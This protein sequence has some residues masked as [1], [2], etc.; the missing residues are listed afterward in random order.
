[1]HFKIQYGGQIIIWLKRNKRKMNEL[2]L[3]KK[4]MNELQ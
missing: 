3:S 2:L 1:M 4:K